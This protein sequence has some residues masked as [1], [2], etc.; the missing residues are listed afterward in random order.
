MTSIDSYEPYL[1]PLYIPAIFGMC[2]LF[3]YYF[4]DLLAFQSENAG[5][6]ALLLLGLFGISSFLTVVYEFSLLTKIVP[7]KALIT[8]PEGAY[9]DLRWIF[10]AIG[11]LS[12]GYVFYLAIAICMQF[13]PLGLR[14]EYGAIT[15]EN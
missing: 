6:G 3:L 7:S 2:F 8:N 1:E 14:D 5:I 10:G 12:V 9:K 15:I 13:L 4:Q 11:L